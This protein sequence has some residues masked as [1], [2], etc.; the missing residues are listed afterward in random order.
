MV[1]HRG[2]SADMY[3]VAKS[4]AGLAGTAM[5]TL[6]GVYS[7]GTQRPFDRLWSNG[8]GNISIV[9]HT[10]DIPVV[11]TVAAGPVDVGGRLVRKTGTTVNEIII[12]VIDNP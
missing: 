11:F 9:P 6:G 1:R 7:T 10:S 2:P 12:A 3:Q 5:G 4:D 8:A